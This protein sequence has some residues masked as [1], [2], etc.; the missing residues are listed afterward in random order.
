M[1]ML[2]KLLCLFLL[3]PNMVLAAAFVEGKDYQIVTNPQTTNNKTKGPL[4][5][6]FFS[7]GCPWCYK[8]E[9]PLQEWIKKTNVPL[10]RVPVVFKPSWE[11]YAKAYYT[12]KTLALSDKFNPILFKAIQVEKNLL[13]SNQ[14]MVN[15]FVIQGIDREIAK[16]AFEGSPT[17]EMKVQNGMALMSTYQIDAVPAF[18]VNNKYKTNLQ[19]AGSPE[20]LI[21]ILD[22]LAR[23]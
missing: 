4:I 3:V 9:A 10:E 11:V 14:D 22:Y 12:A 21:E 19:L 2:K 16:N 8:M 18:V 6:E 17:I 20:R 1:N 7:Y 23:H 15:F 13:E 5:Q